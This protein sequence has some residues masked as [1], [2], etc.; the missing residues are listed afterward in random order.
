MAL[1]MQQYSC[2]SCE[3]HTTITDTTFGCDDVVSITDSVCKTEEKKQR[4]N[5]NKQQQQQ[6]YASEVSK[7]RQNQIAA[8]HID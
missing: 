7:Q 8:C 2:L 1:F 3:T 6:F 5:E 4:K